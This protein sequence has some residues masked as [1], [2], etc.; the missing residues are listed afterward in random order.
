MTMKTFEAKMMRSTVDSTQNGAVL[1]AIMITPLVASLLAIQYLRRKS[2]RSL[3]ISEN[4]EAVKNEP[5]SEVNSL[6]YKAQNEKSDAQNKTVSLP[7]KDETSSK[8]ETSQPLKDQ[9]LSDARSSMQKT[10][11][12]KKRITPLNIDEYAEQQKLSNIV[13]APPNPNPSVHSTKTLTDATPASVTTNRSPDQATSSKRSNAGSKHKHQN[14]TAGESLVLQ[15]VSPNSQDGPNGPVQVHLNSSRASDGATVP[16]DDKS[17]DLSSF[18]KYIDLSNVS[19]PEESKE[20]IRNKWKTYKIFGNKL[21]RKKNATELN[22]ELN[23][24]LGWDQANSL[25]RNLW[26]PNPQYKKKQQS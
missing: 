3:K 5:V 13:S 24:I 19:I 15:L 7:Q 14:K 25:L 2:R 18:E 6:A 11:V 1:S 9:I 12:A 17:D 10:E 8:T 26:Q 16:T 22:K 23:K 20:R 4:K 21:Y